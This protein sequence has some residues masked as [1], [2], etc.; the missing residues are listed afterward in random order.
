LNPPKGK[1][2]TAAQLRYLNGESSDKNRD[3]LLTFWVVGQVLHHWTNFFNVMAK[4][5]KISLPA[6]VKASP[7]GYS[8]AQATAAGAGSHGGNS[9]QR[10]RRERQQVKLQLREPD[11]D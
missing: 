8:P 3:W 7:L 2:G 10:K 11:W 6:E 4:K 5:L 9:R 1:S